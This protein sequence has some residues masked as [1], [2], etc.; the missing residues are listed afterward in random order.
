MSLNR[1]VNK[2]VRAI[3]ALTLTALLLAGLPSASAAVKAQKNP[4]A[5]EV[6]EKAILNY[7]SRTA[8]YAIQ[9]NGILRGLVTL[10]GAEGKREGKTTTKFIRKPRLS[11]DLLLIEVELPDVTY[12]IGFDGK[13]TWSTYNGQ[14]Q[15]A[16]PE[17]SKAFHASH[18]H[19]YEALL[20]YKENNWKLEHAGTDKLGLTDLDIIDLVT[21]DGART[22]YYISR[23]TW[24]I[25][26]L[27]YEVKSAPDAQPTK[28]R[29]AFQ[30]FK[31]IQNT[32]V[33]FETFVYENGNL[34]EKRKLVEVAFNVQLDE[35]VFKPE[36]KANEA[37]IKQ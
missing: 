37:A 11:E 12:S 29:I 6:V 15:E 19:S 36:T 7:G 20:R 22:R 32:L 25:L 21:E 13:T 8:L 2:C 5:E 23:K 9:R 24:H 28:Y 34:I 26:Y 31:A 10:T 33:P 18:T 16:A 4:R 30:A 35:K 17:M 14:R 3:F 1:L 27:E